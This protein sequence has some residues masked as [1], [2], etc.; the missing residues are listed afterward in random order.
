[1]DMKRL[2]QN[3]IRHF[4]PLRD[5]IL[6][7]VIDRDCLIEESDVCLVLAVGDPTFKNKDGYCIEMT[8]QKGDKVLVPRKCSRI[9]AEITTDYFISSMFD[10]LS[11]WK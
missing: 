3:L 5:N 6:F 7:K 2:E 10:V 8:L 9:T 4:K 1:M 11:Y